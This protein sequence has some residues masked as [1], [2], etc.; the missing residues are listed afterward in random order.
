[1]DEISSSESLKYSFT[2]KNRDQEGIDNLTSFFGFNQHSYLDPSI[3]GY[4]LLFVTKPLLFLYP[5]VPPQGSSD[6]NRV[7]AYEN[8]T[9]DPYFS[10]FLLPE[11]G[12][13]KDK[14]IIK[15]L[16]FDDFSDTP[17]YFLPIFT[18]NTLSFSP[19]DITLDTVNLWQTREGYSIA[20]PTSI[21]QSETSGTINIS[22]N[23]SSNLD[24]IKITTLWTKYI[25]N[26]S[27]GTF[28]ANPDM[29]KNNMLDYTSSIYYFVLEPD[30][31]T[32]K[33]WA[34]FTSCFP[35]SAPISALQYQ[36]GNMDKTQ[37]DLSFTYS[38][39]EDMNPKILEDFNM[40]SLK[41]V[42]SSFN[43]Q[44]NELEEYSSFLSDTQVDISNDYVS[45]KNSA[46][47]S[48]EKLQAMYASTISAADRDPIIFY[49][50]PKLSLTTN[51][52]T[53][54]VYKISLGKNSLKNKVLTSI[55]GNS[56]YNY[57]DLLSDL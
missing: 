7:L 52:E 31:T 8:M 40:L 5:L 34:R 44:G 35:L 49:A 21:T 30:G 38:L 17:S 42:N 36:R 47:L 12:N 22:V 9:K 16:S 2:N 3:N 45:Y 19:N 53:T 48:K 56:E 37:I 57:S 4:A 32:L 43:T 39:K 54:G 24:F 6:Y 25:N 23:E 20:M 50:P 33:Y 41:V 13:E 27:N 28:T 29:I 46:L 11:S 10:M 1:M 14:L 15:Q 51:D 26:I 55:T 18:N